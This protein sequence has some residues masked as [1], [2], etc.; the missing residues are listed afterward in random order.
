MKS[1][2]NLENILTKGVFAVTAQLGL[3]KESDVSVIEKK[4]ES[5]KEN[6]DAINVPDNQRAVVRM[7]SMAGAAVLVRMGLE[8]IMHVVT[9]DRNRIAM[10]SDLLGAT[11]LGIKNVFCVTGDHQSLGN[12]ADS[13]NVYDLDSVQLIDCFRTMRDKGTLLGGVEIIERKLGLFIGGA[14]NPFAD[15]LEFRVVRLAKKV[16]AGVDF[17]QTQSVYEMDR[18]KEW[19]G[20]VRDRGLHESV[21]IMAGVTPLKS[22]EMARSMN[23]K[24]PGMIIPEALIDRMARAQKPNEEGIRICVEHIEELKGVHGVHGVHI[25]AVGWEDRVSQIVEMAGLLPRPMVT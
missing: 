18:F 16:Q 7:C 25:S 12:Q 20:M 21:Y 22:A 5:L 19:M 10:Q 14:A 17:I 1:G 3:P 2:S 6:V 23:E 8:P 13:K 9:R 4:A 24:I 15:P 11:A